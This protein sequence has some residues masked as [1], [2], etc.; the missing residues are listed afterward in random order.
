MEEWGSACCRDG[1]H[2][3]ALTYRRFIDD[4]PRL[5]SADDDCLERIHWDWTEK[6]SSQHRFAAKEVTAKKDEK[7]V[8]HE[9]LAVRYTSLVH[10]IACR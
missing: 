2:D 5:F 3:A 10:Y 9:I 7:H 8:L 6:S 1:P 4:A